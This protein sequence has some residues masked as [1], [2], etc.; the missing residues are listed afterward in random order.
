MAVAERCDTDHGMPR[1][2]DIASHHDHET[3]DEAAFVKETASLPRLAPRQQR[4]E[5][6]LILLDLWGLPSPTWR[7]GRRPGTFTKHPD[8]YRAEAFPPVLI[9][10]SEA[11]ERWDE[12]V[13]CVEFLKAEWPRGENQRR[14]VAVAAADGGKKVTT[15][16]DVVYYKKTDHT[17]VS[18]LGLFSPRLSRKPYVVGQLDPE[19]VPNM[20]AETTW[21]AIQGC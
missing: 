4:L 12:A 16:V 10:D 17:A 19:K 8:L 2:K 1:R 6:P 13:Q 15:N 5:F 21:A 14:L 20:F 18:D 3:R 11:W 7:F 9:L